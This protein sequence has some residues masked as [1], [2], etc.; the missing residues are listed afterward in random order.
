M[1]VGRQA[2]WLALIGAHIILATILWQPAPQTVPTPIPVFEIVEHAV[3]VTQLP[4]PPMTEI[5]VVTPV[6]APALDMKPEVASIE[7]SDDCRISEA[8]SEAL[9]HDA[10]AVAAVGRIPAMTRSVANTMMM[11]DGQW[12]N[13]SA[14]G[15]AA[16]LSAIRAAVSDA[17]RSTAA[18]C[19]ATRLTGPRLVIIADGEQT[20]ALVFGSGVWTWD[21]VL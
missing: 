8:I 16:S 2:L 12:A 9:K 5:A 19:R 7:T 15:G 20:A 21:Q 10:N 6:E 13:A 1:S 4:P 11:W 3:A 18:H 17:L 14:L